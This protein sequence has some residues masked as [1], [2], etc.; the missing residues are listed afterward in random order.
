M[1]K[2]L[3]RVSNVEANFTCKGFAGDNYPFDVTPYQ[4]WDF[5]NMKHYDQVPVLSVT[6]EEIETIMTT[7]DYL[8]EEFTVATGAIFRGYTFELN[9]EMEAEGVFIAVDGKR[10]FLVDTGG[11]RYDLEEIK[12]GEEVQQEKRSE[13]N[14]NMKL[15]PSMY[16]RYKSFVSPEIEELVLSLYK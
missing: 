13:F 5:Q 7:L 6:E 14:P 8:S 10:V 1:S 9:K 15:I 2:L 12:E 4:K 11:I 16:P 3:G